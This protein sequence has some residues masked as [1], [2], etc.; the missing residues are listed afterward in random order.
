[1]RALLFPIATLTVILS[2]CTSDHSHTQA[3]SVPAPVPVQVAAVST[4]QWPV[5]YEATGSVRARTTA[6]LASK[7]MAYVRQVAV[8]VGDRV[9]Q[10]QLLVTLDSQDL[11]ANVRRTEAG[12]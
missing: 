11:D 10:G 8:Q 1:M 2:G 9:H 7:V 4:E 5:V 12:E 6:T 3:A